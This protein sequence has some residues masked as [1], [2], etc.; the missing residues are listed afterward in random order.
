M[1]LE[2]AFAV[3]ALFVIISMAT[4]A[5]G[6]FFYGKRL[7]SP[8][9]NSAFPIVVPGW[10]TRLAENPPFAATVA[11][12]AHMNGILLRLAVAAGYDKAEVKERLNTALVRFVRADP[13]LGGLP[14]VVD[15]YGRKVLAK[16]PTTGLQ[17]L[18]PDGT[19]ATKP[20]LVGGWH[21]GNNLFIVF[22]DDLTLDQVAYTHEHG[23]GFHDLKAM[24]DYSHVDQV[25]W[26]PGGIV[27][28]ANAE[29]VASKNS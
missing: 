7:L 3:I 26:G 14:A 9:I 22:T 21:T 8:L 4:L 18:N 24:T 20:M 12:I 17:L 13:S 2:I 15:P 6:L 5:T 11:D 29:F 23:H 19:M 28:Q 25:M 10:G 1:G 27:K 16:D